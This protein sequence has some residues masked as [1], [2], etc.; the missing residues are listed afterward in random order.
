MRRLLQRFPLFLLILGFCLGSVMPACAAGGLLGPQNIIMLVEN[1]VELALAPS[2]ERSLSS[3]DSRRSVMVWSSIAQSID[4]VLL[5]VVQGED[6]QIKDLEG[7]FDRFNAWD[8]VPIG[9]NDVRVMQLLVN[10]VLSYIPTEKLGEA[11]EKGRVPPEVRDVLVAGFT[12]ARDTIRD[13][14]DRH[15]YPTTASLAEPPPDPPEKTL[16]LR[17][18]YDRGD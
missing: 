1:G 11:Y 10:T 5:P 9:D 6:P 13:A 14:L 15:G 18:R 2:V 4:E 12:A 7:W 8:A 3:D 16:E 17:F